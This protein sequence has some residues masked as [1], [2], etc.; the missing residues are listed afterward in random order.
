MPWQLVWVFIAGLGLWLWGREE[1]S[2]AYYI[3]SNILAVIAPIALYYGFAVTLYVLK[4]MPIKRNFGLIV[5]AVVFVTIFTVPIIIMLG[6]IGL[7]DALIDYRKIRW[8]KEG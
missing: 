1:T 3:G 6:L 8:Q 7:F 4:R 2:A 5:L